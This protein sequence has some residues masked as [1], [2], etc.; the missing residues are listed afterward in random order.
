MAGCST[1]VEASVVVLN[2][3]EPELTENCL[4]VLDRDPA[5]PQLERIV[6]DDAS[7][8]DS[9]VRLRRIDGITVVARERNGGFAAAVNSGLAAASHDVV[10]VLNAD[11]QVGPG[12]VRVLIEAALGE[13]VAIAA[14]LLHFPDGRLQMNAYRRFPGVALLMFELTVAG[15]Y[16]IDSAGGR[17]RHPMSVTEEHLRAGGDVEHVMGAAFAVRRAAWAQEPLDE[18][19][20]LY[21]EETEWQRRL[22]RRGWRVVVEP[23]A[24]V[25]H[26][27]RSGDPLAAVPSPHYVTS[28][29]RYLAKQG[30]SRRRAALAFRS[31][32]AVAWLTTWATAL[33]GDREAARGMRER[34]VQLRAAVRRG[35]RAS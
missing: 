13:G 23:R 8:D 22:R 29:F 20:F 12:A 15:G 27:M 2:Y 10:L 5:S 24:R 9:V 34:L 11:T 7:P 21:L 17:L 1:V 31:A 32:L 16:L 35:P 28:A 33:R 19:F 14:P 3:G 26:L 25:T 6:V 18:G 30:V 4:R